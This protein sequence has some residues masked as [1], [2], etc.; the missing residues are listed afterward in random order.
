MEELKDIYAGGFLGLLTT[1][2]LELV[3]MGV[4]SIAPSQY[5]KGVR[6]LTGLADLG[7]AGYSWTQYKTPKSKMEEAF[8]G[9]L[10]LFEGV[11]G[12]LKTV[13]EIID[14]ALTLVGA[15]PAPLAAE[16]KLRAP[17]FA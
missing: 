15:A 10:T 1:T 6:F 13:P 9:S 17:K 4:T 11:T 2:A 14:F 12:T 5:Q 7:I 3:K 8:W 16:M